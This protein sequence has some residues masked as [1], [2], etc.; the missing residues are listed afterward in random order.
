MIDPRLIRDE[1]FVADLPDNPADRFLER[2]AVSLRE[3]A[4][5]LDD[6]FLI[7]GG[8]DRL[9][10]GRLEQSCGL[11]VLHDDSPKA[12]LPRNW[13]VTAIKIT[14]RLSR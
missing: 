7:E 5:C 12:P 13:L 8:D 9:D 2:P 6:E 4:E 1:R 10:G 11:P 14:S 3:L